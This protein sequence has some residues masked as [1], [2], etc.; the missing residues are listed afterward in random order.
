MVSK[1][2]LVESAG[3]ENLLKLRRSQISAYGRFLGCPDL[4]RGESWKAILKKY[5]CPVLRIERKVLER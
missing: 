4:F 1:F 5:R 3:I 2:Y